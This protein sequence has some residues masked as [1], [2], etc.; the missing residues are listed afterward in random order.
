MKLVPYQRRDVEV[1]ESDPTALDVFLFVRDQIAKA[2]PDHE[3]EH[4]GSTSVP[5]LPGK[6][7][8]DVMVLLTD[9]AA[10]TRVAEQLTAA[11]WEHVRGSNPWRPFLLAAVEQDGQSTQVHVHLIGAGSDRGTRRTRAGRGAAR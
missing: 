1:K 9:A 4:I 3:V 7:I 8:V 5:G 10:A 2:P 6:G 11:G